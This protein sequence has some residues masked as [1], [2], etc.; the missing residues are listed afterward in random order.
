[1][2]AVT[3]SA[4]IVAS[5]VSV[6][7]INWFAN[8]N[9]GFSLNRSSN[10]FMLG[11]LAPA[12]RRSILAEEGFQFD[13]ARFREFHLTDINARATQIFWPTG[14][15]PALKE[16]MAGL[17]VEESEARVGRLVKRIVTENPTAVAKIMWQ[18]LLM[19]LDFRSYLYHFSELLWL[20]HRIFDDGFVERHVHP[21]AWQKIDK[22]LPGQVTLSE[23]VVRNAGPLVWLQ[24]LIALLAPLGLLNRLLR[25]SVLYM[26]FALTASGYAATTIFF[27]VGT[28]PRY[29]LPLFPLSLAIVMLVLSAVARR[30]STPGQ[31]SGRPRRRVKNGPSSEATVVRETP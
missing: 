14:L 22:A 30:H 26:L 23:I 5:I 21:K 9:L 31:M 12:V 20:D 3:A 1:L 6:L 24:H 19:N 15:I 25:R 2:A 4:A 17:S 28:I 7:T 11:V 16:R 10:D 29:F 8:P 27:S 13:E 18:Q